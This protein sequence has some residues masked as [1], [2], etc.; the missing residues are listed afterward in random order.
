MKSNTGHHLSALTGSMVIFGTIGLFRRF[1]P[2]PSEVL[3][4]ARG[5]MGGLFLLLLLKAR[6]RSFDRQAVRAHWKLLVL[7]GAMIGFNW[8]L[9]FEAYN[10]TT[11]AIATLCYYLQP[12]IVILLSPLVLG[13]RV[14]LRKGICVLTALAGM[15]LVSGIAGSDGLPSGDLRGVFLGLG[16]AV[17]Y[18]GVVLLNKR[19]VGVP[20]YEKTVLQLLSASLV[21]LPYMAAAGTLHA[22]SLGIGQAA[23]LVTVGIVHTGM[24]YV[25]YFGSVEHLPAQT[26]AL[27]GY[28]DPVTAVFLSVILL[29]EP[30]SLLT[31]AGAVLILGSA[32]VSEL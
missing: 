32:A 22:Y 31:L 20:V 18:A 2:L 3:A 10:Y 12:V 4:C 15:V 6:G 9:L 13:E 17:L 1:I 27:F 5:I 14:S 25:L 21:L 29:H 11:V 16:A 8:I 26:A 19:I 23:A 30:M 7:S 24:A 28:I